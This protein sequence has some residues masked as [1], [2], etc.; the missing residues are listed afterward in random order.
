MLW[1]EVEDAGRLP[2]LTTIGAGDFVLSCSDG[3]WLQR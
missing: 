1:G 2:R 3:G